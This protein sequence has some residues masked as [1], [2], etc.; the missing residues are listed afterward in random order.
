MPNFLITIFLV[1]A[2]A[3][4]CNLTLAENLEL[5]DV[6]KPGEG[7]YVSSELIYP[8]GDKP[9]PQC[10]ASTQAQLPNGTLV[11]A[12]FGGTREK[13]SDVGIWFSHRNKSGWSKPVELVDG[14]EGEERE[15][16][17]WNP[18]LFQPK[19]GPLFLFYKVGLD[20]RRWWGM[21]ITSDDGGT[22]WSTPRKLG[23]NERLGDAN[24]NLI[25]RME[26][27]SAPAVPN[28]TAGGCTLN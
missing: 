24:M 2:T 27:S 7:G 11:A 18:V 5:P 4:T 10:H 6:A 19:D 3:G 17:C 8:L 1:I 14:S 28:T 22:S 16:A 12:W 26:R 13:N 20:P 15:Y 21:L 23:Q 25:L 9:T